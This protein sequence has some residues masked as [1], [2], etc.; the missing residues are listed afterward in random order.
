MNE[1]IYPMSIGQ[2]AARWQVDVRTVRR[3]IKPFMPELGH[4]NGKI[5]TVRQVK[6][7]LEHLE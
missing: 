6:I 4:I 1:K 7:I 5:F 3:W 2:L